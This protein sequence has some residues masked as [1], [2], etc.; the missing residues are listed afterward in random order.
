VLGNLKLLITK[1]TIPDVETIPGKENGG[2]GEFN[3]DVFYELLHMSQCT[4][5]TAIMW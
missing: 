4:P 1:I 2:G 5:G 3:Y